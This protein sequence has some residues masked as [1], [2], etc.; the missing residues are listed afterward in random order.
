MLEIHYV[1]YYGK[2]NN[3]TV[4]YEWDKTLDSYH[5]HYNGE[6]Q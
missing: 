2:T 3:I 5:K 6:G 4:T 1:E